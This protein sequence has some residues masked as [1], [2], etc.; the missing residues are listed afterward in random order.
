M[1]VT[2]QQTLSLHSLDSTEPC[3]RNASAKCKCKTTPFLFYAG[4]SGDCVAGSVPAMYYG[5]PYDLVLCR[6][7]H[8]HASKILYF[9]C[10]TYLDFT[11][12]L[13]AVEH[14]HKLS[15]PSVSQCQ[16]TSAA[17]SH[18]NIYILC[19]CTVLNCHNCVV[20]GLQHWLTANIRNPQPES[21]SL[22]KEKLKAMRASHVTQYVVPKHSKTLLPC[23]EV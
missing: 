18:C 21:Q 9:H 6:S 22:G 11:L 19:F 10:H 17:K 2:W 5:W 8:C 7:S 23:S 4:F 20:S 15:W 16:F 1:T 14:K 3:E 13:A 12:A